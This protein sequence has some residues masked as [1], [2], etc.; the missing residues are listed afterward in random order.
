MQRVC[1]KLGFQLRTTPEVVEAWVDLA[2]WQPPPDQRD[3]P[4][5]GND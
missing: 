3:Q 1:R 2:G 5:A 4:V